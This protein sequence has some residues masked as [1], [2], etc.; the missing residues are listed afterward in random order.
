MQWKTNITSPAWQNALSWFSHHNAVRYYTKLRHAYNDYLWFISFIFFLKLKQFTSTPSPP[1]KGKK[2]P[3]LSWL[4]R[5][6]GDPWHLTEHCKKRPESRQS[7]QGL[8][9]LLLSDE[10]CGPG[11]LAFCIL[12]RSE[13]FLSCLNCDYFLT[14]VSLKTNC[15][16]EVGFFK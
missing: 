4:L 14:S 10:F 16:S 13:P 6:P 12:S 3:T 9:T 7:R 5:F 8:M 1:M 15:R 11:K 2:N